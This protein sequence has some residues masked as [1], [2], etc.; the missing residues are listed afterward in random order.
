[1]LFAFR[2]QNSFW[3]HLPVAVAVII[4]AALHGVSRLEWAILILCIAVVLAA[5]LFNSAIEHLAQAITDEESPH[6]RD[7]LDVAGGAVLVASLGALTVGSLILLTRLA[8]A[9]GF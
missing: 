1:M 7:A 8:A 4:G 3:V 2:T 6:L 9:L 5:E